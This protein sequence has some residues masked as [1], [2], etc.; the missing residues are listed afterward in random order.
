MDLGVGLDDLNERTLRDYPY[1]MLKVPD[2]ERNRKS[3]FLF[4]F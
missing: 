2:Y 4:Y 1:V 3:T